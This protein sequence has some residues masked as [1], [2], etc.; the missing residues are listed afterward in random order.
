MLYNI[1]TPEG[2]VAT[3]IGRE[4]FQASTD[5]LVNTL[6]L[7]PKKLQSQEYVSNLCKKNGNREKLD[8]GCN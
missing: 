7:S 6:E 5:T 2:L 4:V 1:R 3:S 8:L